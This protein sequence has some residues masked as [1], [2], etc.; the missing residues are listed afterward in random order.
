MNGSQF[1]LV[2]EDNPDDVQLARMAFARSRVPVNLVV[3]TDGE[4]ALDFLR[5]QGQYANRD[6]NDQPA[7]VILDLKLPWMSGQ[8][9][10]KEIRLDQRTGRLP[11][12][13]VSS[14]RNM[15]EIEECETFGLNRYFP[16]PSNYAQYRK[17][18]TE[19]RR[20]WLS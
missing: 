15:Q 10:L 16:K 1:I 8:E 4:E 11:V 12:V 13:V 9:V 5:G 7:V 19:I 18:I 6:I 14:T 2:I 17:I 3:V 20:S